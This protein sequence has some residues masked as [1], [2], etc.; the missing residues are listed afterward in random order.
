MMYINSYMF[1]L[2]GAIFRELLQQMCTSRPANICFLTS[3]CPCIVNII[4]NYNQQD[5]TFLNLF[6]STDALHVSGCSYAHHQEHVTVHTASGIVNRYCCRCRAFVEINKSRNICTLLVVI[7]KYTSICDART[8]EC[9]IYKCQTGKR[10]IP[11][12]KHQNKM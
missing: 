1:R 2:R 8:Y 4:P 3:I 10:K 7:R 5:A 9:Q 11:I 6:I 12:Q